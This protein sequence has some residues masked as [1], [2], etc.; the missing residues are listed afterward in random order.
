MRATVTQSG[1]N[2]TNYGGDKETV[3]QLKVVAKIEGKDG[4]RVPFDARFYMGRSRTAATV[5]CTVW[6]HGYKDGQEVYTS[7]TGRAGGYGYHKQSAALADALRDAGVRLF[8]SPYAGREDEDPTKECS[9]SGCGSSSMDTAA[10]AVAR[11][12]G[13]VLTPGE[14][15]IIN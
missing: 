13:A 1:Y 7:G 4:L 5:Y 11:E 15:M 9:I 2:G 3:G 10:E 8:G 12:V 6:V 14:F